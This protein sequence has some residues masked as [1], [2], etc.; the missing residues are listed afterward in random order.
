M[1]SITLLK[2]TGKTKDELIALLAA[3]MSRESTNVEFSDSLMKMSLQMQEQLQMQKEM[4]TWI[5]QQQERQEKL[6]QVMINRGS[7]LMLGEDMATTLRVKP[8]RPIL[9]KVTPSDDVESF[10]DLFEQVVTQQGQ[11]VN[12]WSTQLA[13]LLSR[14]SFGRLYFYSFVGS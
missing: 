2:T 6:M 8:P 4:R 13:G 7:S 14:D 9:Q 3:K 10:I 5:S 1:S 11:P 12:I